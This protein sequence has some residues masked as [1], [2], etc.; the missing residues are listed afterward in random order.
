MFLQKCKIN[1]LFFSL[2]EKRA[3]AFEMSQNSK[4]KPEKECG[5]LCSSWE[6]IKP[7]VIIKDVIKDPNALDLD[8]F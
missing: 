8:S 5:K 6:I 7:E 1:F 3:E 4:E 2:K